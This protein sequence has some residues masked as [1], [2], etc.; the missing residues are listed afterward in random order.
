[1]ERERPVDGGIEWH[2]DLNAFYCCGCEEWIPV[3]SKVWSDPERLLAMREA[4]V[5]DHTEC[6]EYDDPRMA[7]NA[8]RFRKEAKRQSNLAAQRVSWRGRG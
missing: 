7:R 5:A 4:L 1:M 8:R 2:A 6:W 3:R